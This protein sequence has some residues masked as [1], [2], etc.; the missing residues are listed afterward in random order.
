MFYDEP[1]FVKGDIVKLNPTIDLYKNSPCYRNSCELKVHQE[2]G[3]QH[4]HSSIAV[5]CKNPNC[6][7]KGKVKGFN[8]VYLYV[9]KTN[10]VGRQALKLA[11]IK[12]EEERKAREKSARFQQILQLLSDFNVECGNYEANQILDHIE[13][14]QMGKEDIDLVEFLGFV[15]KILIPF[16]SSHNHCCCCQKD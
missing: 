14:E 13:L 11:T 9:I 2:K 3:N 12:K 4:F 7:D 8:S 15:I 5:V 10:D 16:S 6:K 1:D